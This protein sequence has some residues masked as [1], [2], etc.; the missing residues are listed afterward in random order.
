METAT[1][2]NTDCPET[3]VGEADNMRVDMNWLRAETV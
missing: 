2:V 3:L 1:G